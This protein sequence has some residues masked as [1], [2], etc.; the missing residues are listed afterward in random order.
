MLVHTWLGI[1]NVDLIFLTAVVGAAVRYGLLP[2][3]FATVVAS[4][5]D[6]FFFLPPVYTFTI[7]P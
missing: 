5:C 4:L 7:G 2:S 3:R 6:N 1:E